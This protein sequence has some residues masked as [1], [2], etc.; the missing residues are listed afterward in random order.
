MGKGARNRK[1]RAI[2]NQPKI[3]VNLAD[4]PLYRCPKCEKEAFDR[5]EMIKVVSRLITGLPHDKY[6]A[7][8]MYRCVDCGY[9][10]CNAGE[11]TP[12]AE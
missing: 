10:L 9:V 11:P 8:R 12:G 1:I 2:N 7:R 3:N 4:C 6:V 5:V